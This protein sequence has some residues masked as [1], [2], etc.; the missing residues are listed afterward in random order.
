MSDRLVRET[1][2]EKNKDL[3]RCARETKNKNT[4]DSRVELG[5]QGIDDSLPI[6]MR[7][8]ASPLRTAYA[9]FAIQLY[10]QRV[11][12]MTA[13]ADSNTDAVVERGITVT[14]CRVRRGHLGFVQFEADLRLE[15][16]FVSSC[17][18]TVS[19]T[20]NISGEVGL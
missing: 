10:I 12:N 4:V 14:C 17:H 3:G 8:E 11:V 9:M 13:R 6:A 19:C 16:G 20:D 18:L 15:E 7:S 5:S 2:L 1:D